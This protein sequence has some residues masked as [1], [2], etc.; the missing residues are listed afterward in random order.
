MSDEDKFLRGDQVITRSELQREIE[1]EAA[2]EPAEN[3]RLGEFN[4][5]D[6][7]VESLQVGLLR[8][9]DE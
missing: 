2:D 1:A 5:N 6:W 4:F 3:W 9:V 8:R 7:L